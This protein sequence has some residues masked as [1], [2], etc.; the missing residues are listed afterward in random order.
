MVR[1]AAR[2]EVAR[3]L[4][5]RYEVSER[6]ACRTIAFSR[7]SLRYRSHLDPRTA[8]RIR[9]RDIAHTRVRYGYRRIR[10]MLLREGWRVSTNL[11]YRLYREEGLALRTGLRRR[12]RASVQRQARAVPTAPN[13]AWTLDFVSDQLIDGARF[14]ALTVLDIHTRQCLA[15]R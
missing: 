1:P 6:R 3:Y 14:R 12:R 13:H 5:Q 4:R 10:V 11:V 9:M 7:A 8:L 15:S 2:R